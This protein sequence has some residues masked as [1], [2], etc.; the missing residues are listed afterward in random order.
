LK[1]VAGLKGEAKTE[2]KRLAGEV[3]KTEGTKQ[4]E[5]LAELRQLN[6]RSTE[7]VS[8]GQRLKTLKKVKNSN[9]AR[10]LEGMI[11]DRMSSRD[12]G[13]VMKVVRLTEKID[14]L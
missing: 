2:L 9:Q 6:T 3:K 1:K 8:D 5:A 12:S 14:S 13:D 4:A 7:S 10:E 11:K